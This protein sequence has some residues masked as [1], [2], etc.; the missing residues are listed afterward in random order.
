MALPI[1]LCHKM[2]SS[3]Y[4]LGHRCRQNLL[5]NLYRSGRSEASPAQ[6]VDREGAGGLRDQAEQGPSK[7]H[8]Q[9]EGKG[10]H[11]L[12]DHGGSIRA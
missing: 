7:H 4:L 12:A 1:I 11:Q 10:R 3:Y 2:F 5:V 6:E 8:L 9:E